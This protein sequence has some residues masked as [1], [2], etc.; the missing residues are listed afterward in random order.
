MRP[1]SATLEHPHATSTEPLVKTQDI[2][3]ALSVTTRYVGILTAE[4]RIPSHKFGRR[5][6]RYRLSDV[7]KAL[8]AEVKS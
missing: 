1:M 6:I 5:C 8:G 3:K 2:A 4:G 7:L